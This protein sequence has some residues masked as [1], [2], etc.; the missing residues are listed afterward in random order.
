[1]K[2]KSE[3]EIK[4]E[5]CKNYTSNFV[6]TAEYKH[7]CRVQKPGFPPDKDCMDNYIKEKDNAN[8]KR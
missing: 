4:C 1:M 5:Y 3:T 6:T 8:G 2:S 7:F